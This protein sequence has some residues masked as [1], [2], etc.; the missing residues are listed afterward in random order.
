MRKNLV[1]FAGESVS[2]DGSH[3]RSGRL[4][5]VVRNA[6]RKCYCLSVF[7]LEDR[8][9]SR[10]RLRVFVPCVSSSPPTDLLTDLLTSEQVSNTFFSRV[11]DNLNT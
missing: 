5:D 8:K 4:L 3:E 10:A 1:V 11:R 2:K 7:H 6:H 9:D